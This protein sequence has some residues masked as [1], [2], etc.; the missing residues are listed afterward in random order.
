MFERN[1]LGGNGYKKLS[2]LAF[3]LLS[4]L[5]INSAMAAPEF[6]ANMPSKS[7]TVQQGESVTKNNV[8]TVY[9]KGTVGS[10]LYFT[11][12]E[13]ANWLSLSPSSG[14][15]Y[16]SGS[17]WGDEDIDFN[18]NTSGLSVGNHSCQ[19]SITSNC[20]LY[21]GP[22]SS[23]ISVYVTSPPDPYISG[24]ITESDGTPVSG[25][26]VSFNNGGGSDTTDSNGNYSEQVPYGWSGTQSYSKSG[27][28]FSPGSVS[29][30]NVTSDQT[31]NITATGPPEPQFSANYSDYTHALEAGDSETADNIWY[32]M[33]IGDIGSSCN[34][35]LTKITAGSDWLTLAPSSGTLNRT[36]SAPPQQYI[37]LAF[38]ASGLGEGQYQCDIELTST[39]PAAPGPY[40]CTVTMNVSPPPS[41]DWDIINTV[42]HEMP[43]FEPGQELSYDVTV[44][45]IGSVDAPASKLRLKSYDRD[46]GYDEKY[47]YVDVPAMTAGSSTTVSI[48][49]TGGARTTILIVEFLA[50]SDGLPETNY[51][52]N[53]SWIL[54]VNGE[55]KPSRLFGDTQSK[56]GFSNDPVNT[57][58]GNFIKDHTDL[59]VN[60]RFGNL[61]FTRYYNSLSKEISCL[62]RGWRHSFMY[63]LDLTLIGDSGAPVG[64]I[65]PDG[66]S[67]YWRNDG[68]GYAP[69]F[70]G[71]FGQM[72]QVGSDWQL[73]QK[74]LTQYIFNAGGNLIEITDKNGNTLSFTY[75]GGNLSSIIDPAGRTLT[76]TY[77]GDKLTQV[78]DWGAR[79]VQYTYSSDN[80]DMVT[81]VNGN[82]LLYGYD[83]N[84]Y[85]NQVTDQRGVV[86]LK[87]IY[88]ASGRVTSQTD[89]NNNV[90]TFAYDTPA[91]YATTVTNPLGDTIV[92]LHND[93]YQLVEL[94]NELALSIFY[95]YD[96]VLELRN[97]I[98]DRIGGVTSF[99]YDSRGNVTK[100]TYPDSTEVTV[101]YNSFDLPVSKTDQLGNIITWE[102]DVYGN[103]VKETNASAISRN[104]SYNAY[105]QI[106]S[107]QDFNGST[108]NYTYDSD[109]LLTQKQDADGVIETYS[110]DSLWRVTGVADGN[111]N[112]ITT[113]YTS[114]GKVQSVTNPEGNSQAYTYDEIGNKLTETDARGK[115][116]TYEYDNNSNL[117]KVIRPDSLGTT[118]YEYDS[119]NRKAKLTD[120]SGNNWNY[121]YYADGKLHNETTPDGGLTIYTY[122]NN[123]NM[124]TKTDPTGN[125][126]T[127]EYDLMNRLIRSKD[128]LNHSVDFEYDVIGQKTATIDAKG[129]RTEYSYDALGNLLSVIQAGNITSYEYDNEGRL[130][131]ITDA[132]SSETSIEYTDAGRRLK[133][134]DPLN[135]Q[136]SYGYDSVGQLQS[137]THPDGLSET[138]SYDDAGRM[139]SKTYVGD[140]TI[141]YSFDGNGNTV[142][143]TDAIGT[144]GYFYDALNRLTTVTDSYGQAVSY[145]YDLSGNRTGITYPG[146]KTVTYSYDSLNRLSSVVDWNSNTI[147]Y[148]YDS[149]GRITSK[150][151][152]NGISMQKT[153]DQAG[154]LTAMSYTKNA[155][156]TTLVSYAISYDANG[157]PTSVNTQG[158][159]NPTLLFNQT[160]NYQ[161]DASHQITTTSEGTYSHAPRG[162]MTS[163]IVNGIATDFTFA[164]DGMMTQQQT[165]GNIVSHVYDGNKNRVARIDSGGMTRFVLDRTAAMSHV[166]CTTDDAGITSEYFVRGHENVACHDSAGNLKHYY[167]SDPFGNVVA[168]ADASG[169]ITDTYLYSP[170][171]ETIGRTGTT[172]NPFMF[173]GALGVMADA[174]GLYFMR[175]RF[176]DPATGRFI[177]VDPIEGKPIEPA[178]LHRYLYA[179]NN[180]N[181]YADPSGEI[182]SPL[183]IGCILYGAVDLLYKGMLGDLR[184]SDIAY[185]MAGLEPHVGT[186]VTAAAI[187]E[188]IN[189][190]RGIAGDIA[191]L[192]ETIESG[193][194]AIKDLFNGEGNGIDVVPGIGGIVREVK[195][196]YWETVSFTSV[197]GSYVKEQQKSIKTKIN[198]PSIEETDIHIQNIKIKNWNR[199]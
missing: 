103:A 141:N 92:H 196:V 149:A 76:L 121:S 116:T 137:L 31:Q 98:T 111:G 70:A 29:W 80:L 57:A 107:E 132:K 178:T 171:G 118:Q 113:S 5:L 79:T 50:N 84:N 85:L 65:Y 81:D 119:L 154:R 93:K 95:T 167:L 9:N 83:G 14:S 44:E 134:T 131:K 127:N 96:P 185:F 58:T 189:E 20:P 182:Y 160:V 7:Y 175:A 198:A 75:V 40:P 90:S 187:T 100:T 102:Y 33:N 106:L 41:P 8:W 73:T 61:Q 179:M 146:G 27:Y 115:T 117:T 197:T 155:G 180:T 144:T 138:Y 169:S 108:T 16:R 143:M 94:Q 62:G 60:T 156:S 153:Y 66:H 191:S 2:C 52:N 193:V 55:T 24:R 130:M 126:L 147:G 77:S 6:A 190:K 99:L 162:N 161:Y 35:T 128:G 199:F 166:L 89:G 124:L 157:N 12:S 114:D 163:R 151:Y 168:L 183:D 22:Y 74:D 120:A 181:I 86:I 71:T 21:P 148:T 10:T 11:F 136:A 158:L 192:P 18:I 64:V 48:S 47:S 53:D 88:D 72:Q 1:V 176:Y 110:Y 123:G 42:S 152:P 45:N 3:L 139:V 87:N 49:T 32:M 164:A 173:C 28:S 78:Q 23:S 43:P 194:D 172:E 63:Q 97:S 56:T 68:G 15:V 150:S 145:A 54:W 26:S 59:S 195:G 37:D 125:V 30:N 25:V 174:D 165:G 13:S 133:T 177:S 135:R 51:D 69:I 39:D 122:D 36:G 4:V 91:A 188:D 142:T 46:T 101:T 105:G 140:G 184:E 109:G 170:F 67:E 112:T 159:P 129:N 38:N 17:A 34:F 19:V 82:N 104:L 186:V